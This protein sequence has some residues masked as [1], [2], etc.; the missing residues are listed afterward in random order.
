MLFVTHI[1]LGVLLY[2]L[3]AL[4]LPI[5]S[6]WLGFFAYL[7]GITAPDLDHKNSKAGRSLKPV[8][9]LLNSVFGHRGLVHSILGALLISFLFGLIIQFIGLASNVTIWFFFGFLAH[10][11]G[12]SLTPNG[13]AWFYPFSKKKFRSFIRTGSMLEVLFLAIILVG[14]WKFGLKFIF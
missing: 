3:V 8:S 1:F 13:I 11:V 4:T 12:D 6:N 9:W 2:L 5:N 14:I 7:L 10:L